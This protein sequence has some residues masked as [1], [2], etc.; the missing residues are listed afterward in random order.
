[1]KDAITKLANEYKEKYSKNDF[2]KASLN[3]KK[4]LK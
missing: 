4:L 2:Y 3:I 1:M